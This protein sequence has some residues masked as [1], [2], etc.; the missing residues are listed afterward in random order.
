MVRKTRIKNLNISLIANKSL[1]LS[2]THFVLT[3]AMFSCVL[4]SYSQTRMGCKLDKVAYESILPAY[5][6]MRGERQIPLVHSLK[7]FVPKPQNQGEFGTCVAW[8]SAYYARSMMLADKNSWTTQ[9]KINEKAGSPFFIYEQIKSYSDLQCQEGAGLIVALEAL[10][11][12]GTV[13]IKRFARSCGQPIAKELLIE[14]EKYRIAEYRRLFLAN[15]KDK[16]SPV[17]RVIAQNKP[18]VIGLQC[19]TNSFI[20][21]K[22]SIWKPT[23]N[24]LKQILGQEGGHALCVVGYDDSLRAFEVVNSWGANWANRG[25]IWIS[26]E[27]FEQVCFEAYEMYEADEPAAQIVGEVK[28]TLSAG[29]DIPLHLKDGYYESY[30]TYRVGTLLRLMISNEE[31]IFVYAFTSDLRGSTQVIFPKD[32]KIPLLYQSQKTILPDE[33][34]YIELIENNETDYFC[35]LYSKEKL[36]LSSIISQL[37]N[38]EGSLQERLAKILG[39]KMIPVQQ[40][41]FQEIAS[42]KFAA[43]TEKATI[44]PLIIAVKK[45]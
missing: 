22:D 4:P 1:S 21:A 27:V 8:T 18:V 12:Y 31:P 23:N 6:P 5:C 32:Q 41:S 17:K 2:I 20:A 9:E 29:T 13:P 28:L 3:W 33:Q 26:Y 39:S 44:L 19:F 14:A 35:I 16:V 25:F 43:K 34:H 36:H 11:Q 37:E 30:D 10:K 7:K 24:E 40:I 15:T 42:V 45:R 38:L